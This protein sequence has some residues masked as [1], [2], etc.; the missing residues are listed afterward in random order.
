VAKRGFS[1]FGNGVT[2]LVVAKGG[3]QLFFIKKTLK[4]QAF[5]KTMLKSVWCFG[6]RYYFR[7]PFF[8]KETR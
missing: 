5:E 7:S 3:F 6:K 2:V 1:V 8:G 4:K